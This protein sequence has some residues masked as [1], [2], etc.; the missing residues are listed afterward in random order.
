MPDH[1]A[2][3]SWFAMGACQISGY[4]YNVAFPMNGSFALNL[5]SVAGKKVLSLSGQ[6]PS[7]ERL[8]IEPLPPGLYLLTARQNGQTMTEKIVRR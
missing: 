8:A 4:L 2:A 1:K 3:D 5:V 7:V 6:G